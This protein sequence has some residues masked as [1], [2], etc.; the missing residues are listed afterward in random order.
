M[1]TPTERKFPSSQGANPC[2]LTAILNT[3]P[4][5]ALTAR[6]ASSGLLLTNTHWATEGQEEFQEHIFWERGVSSHQVYK[7]LQCPPPGFDELAIGCRKKHETAI[8]APHVTS[9]KGNRKHCNK[10]QR[11]VTYSLSAPQ[12]RPFRLTTWTNIPSSVKEHF[13]LTLTKIQHT[14]LHMV[15][16]TGEV[17]EEG[18]TTKPKAWNLHLQTVGLQRFFFLWINSTEDIPACLGLLGSASTLFMQDVKKYFGRLAEQSAVHPSR[19]F[20]CQT[21]KILLVLLKQEDFQSGNN[22]S[23]EVNQSSWSFS[24]TIENKIKDWRKR[25]QHRKKL[26]ECS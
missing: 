10:K 19:V 8:N 12:S 21:K 6:H 23:K 7:P 22:C 2:R 11:I 1:E 24:G 13:S 5:Q 17:R 25:K 3:V 18:Q 26:K 14:Q 20:T 4:S 15:I 16:S 9:Q